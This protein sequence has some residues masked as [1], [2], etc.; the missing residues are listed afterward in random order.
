[1]A[2]RESRDHLQHN[3]NALS[4]CSQNLTRGCVAYFPV[5]VEGAR[6]SVGDM[7][8]SEG[9]GEISLCGAIE[10]AGW[11]HLKV[12][13]IK[14]GMA[15][16]NITK[17]PLFMSSNLEPR[18]SRY[19]TF[20]GISVDYH[21]QKEEDNNSDGEQKYLDS[22]LAYKNACRNAI[23]HLKHFGWTGEQVYLLLS[24]VPL[25]GRLAGVVDIPNACATLA[26]PMDVFDVNI[27]PGQHHDV[28]RKERG[29]VPIYKPPSSKSE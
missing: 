20:E 26:L 21:S 6:L 18:Y 25:E 11:L 5:F 10:M 4:R 19:L 8:F 1:M 29:Q 12:S 3:T 13:V 14:Q 2:E 7:H 15:K 9:D 22:T 27:E 17:N 23:T 24:A 28:Q 16:Y